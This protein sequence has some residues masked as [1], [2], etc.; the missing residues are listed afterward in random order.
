MADTTPKLPALPLSL[1]TSPARMSM[2][3][4][5]GELAMQIRRWG[6]EVYAAAQLA[7]TTST[8]SALGEPAAEVVGNFG[9]E[10]MIDTPLPIG[11]KLYLA[12]S[13]T[14][15]AVP[16]APTS[17]QC[18]DGHDYQVS[19]ARTGEQSCTLCGKEWE[20]F[21]TATTASVSAAS[22]VDP[23]MALPHRTAAE[24][25]ASAVLTPAYKAEQAAKNAGTGAALA[26]L[27]VDESEGGH[28]D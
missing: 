4:K 11:T 28:H 12:P 16:Q 26:Q 25:G 27:A 5:A 21:A 19:N 15:Q 13:S 1:D 10:G 22:Q 6:Y 18:V 24:W 9:G 3:V 2:H 20:G 7:A 23:S 8:G 14:Q 17:E